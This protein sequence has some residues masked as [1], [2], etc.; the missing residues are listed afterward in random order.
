LHAAGI[1]Q[2]RSEKPVPTVR[3]V[4]YSQVGPIMRVNST[5]AFVLRRIEYSKT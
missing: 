5:D 1:S 4:G 2:R 3:S